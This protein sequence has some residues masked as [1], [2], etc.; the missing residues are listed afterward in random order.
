MRYV[1]VC[2]YTAR[3]NTREF[4]HNWYE[5]RYIRLS[6]MMMVFADTLRIDGFGYENCVEFGEW[7]AFD[8]VLVR[9]DLFMTFQIMFY[10]N[11]CHGTQTNCEYENI[12]GVFIFCFFFL[13]SCH[14]QWESRFEIAIG[15]HQRRWTA[16]GLH[17][18]NAIGVPSSP[19]WRSARITGSNEGT[20]DCN[21]IATANTSLAGTQ[22]WDSSSAVIYQIHQSNAMQTIRWVS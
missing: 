9:I 10:C 11:N 21:G 17:L 3:G 22:T 2:A 18:H 15:Q 8:N 16:P 6:M 13:S 5:F 7:L 4:M 1:C 14:S 20:N 19:S 12:F